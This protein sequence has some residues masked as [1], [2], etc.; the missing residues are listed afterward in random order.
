MLTE[1][2]IEFA[3]L[4]PFKCVTHLRERDLSFCVLMH[5]SSFMIGRPA[6]LISSL[7][8]LSRSA[9]EPEPGRR[10]V[11]GHGP[12]LALQMCVCVSV[13]WSFANCCMRWFDLLWLH[14]QT[15]SWRIEPKKKKKKRTRRSLFVFVP[16]LWVCMRACVCKRETF[17]GFC[18]SMC[19]IDTVTSPSVGC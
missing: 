19:G 6:C 17:V 11:V 10:Q 5:T 14:V 12:A 16:F 15:S 7:P 1:F 2:L 9:V 4:K 18:V 3:T 8:S 13:H